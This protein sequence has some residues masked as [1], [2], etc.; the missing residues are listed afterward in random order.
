M[1]G[2]Q[3]FGAAECAE[4]IWV[5]VFVDKGMG[6]R[7]GRLDIRRI[8]RRTLLCSFSSIYF[9]ASTPISQRQSVT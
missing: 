4:F 7:Y 2:F 8:R 6:V 3:D 9:K 5:E 1:E